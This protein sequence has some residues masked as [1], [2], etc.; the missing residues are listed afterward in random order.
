MQLTYHYHQDE[1]KMIKQ[2]V[3]EQGISK[4]LLASIK[5]QGGKIEV[6]G[7][8]ENVLY[9]L[10]K[11]DVLV[12][13]L[14]KEEANEHVYLD[15]TPLQILYEDD[16]FLAV[17]KPAGVPSV[18][19]SRY[20]NETMVNRVA[21][22]F[23]TQH[24][25]NQVVH[26]ITRLDKDT[27]GVMLFAKHR[28]AHALMDQAL[29]QK[30]IQ[31]QY[32]AIVSHPENLEEHGMI[33]A[34]IARTAPHQMRRCVREDGKQAKTEYW[35]QQADDTKAVVRI[36]LHTGRTHQIRVHFESIGCPLLGDALYDGDMALINRQ[37]LHCQQLQFT[38]PLTYEALT[39][40]TPLPHDM[41]TLASNIKIDE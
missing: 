38:H 34:P 16:H 2:F 31:K 26:V 20:L 30:T 28:L 40:A 21:H 23:K 33:D 41:A 25:D 10:Q 29:Q 3:R 35:M 27:S 7:H 9:R 19:V 17:V 22:Y 4:G 32:I 1:P 8:E 14:P 6:N 5:F 11:D 15:D 24:Y 12:L 18:P 13:T 36:Q 37:A 39:I